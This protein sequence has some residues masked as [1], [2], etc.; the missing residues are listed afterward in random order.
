[1]GV[2]FVGLVVWFDCM[3]WCV[4]FLIFCLFI[5]IVLVVF[6]RGMNELVEV[7]DV[8][9]FLKLFLISSVVMV[10]VILLV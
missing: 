5:S 4:V 3:I 8:I 6:F 10:F 7:M 1:M 9:W 2:L